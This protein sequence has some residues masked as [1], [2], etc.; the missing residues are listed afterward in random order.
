MDFARILYYISGEIHEYLKNC[1]VVE[2]VSLETF[3]A[4]ANRS[5][6]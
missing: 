5:A 6:L 2:I 1:E 3:V 4:R